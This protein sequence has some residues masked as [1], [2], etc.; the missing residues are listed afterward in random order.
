MAT[1]R[2]EQPA[3]Q[4][5]I[6]TYVD[7]P[8]QA[9]VHSLHNKQNQY[10]QAEAQ[11][12]A[13]ED[14]FLKVQALTQDKTKRDELID[15]Y[16]K[17][18]SIK[19][20]AVRGDYSQLGSYAKGQAQKIKSDLSYGQLGA[21][22]NNYAAAQK[23]QEEQHDRF[24]K[25]NITAEDYQNALDDSHEKY[26]G[27][28]EKVNGSYNSFK[29]YEHADYQ[30]INKQAIDLVNGWQSDGTYTNPQSN[31]TIWSAKEQTFVP[32]KEV[33]DAA[34]NMVSSNEKNK[35]YVK[36]KSYFAS[37]GVNEN[38]FDH[39]TADANLKKIY[40]DKFDTSKF[41]AKQK[42]SLL[43]AHDMYHTAADAAA[44]KESFLKTKLDWKE[45][46]AYGIGLRDKLDKK[47]MV[48]VNQSTLVPGKDFDLTKSADQMNNL[49]LQIKEIQTKLDNKEG[50]AYQLTPQLEDLK[51]QKTIISNTVNRSTSAYYNTK[52]GQNYIN[53]EFNN[54]KTAFPQS[55]IKNI[56]EYKQAIIAA[57]PSSTQPSSRNF[58]LP[59]EM[60]EA[61][62]LSQ[63]GDHVKKESTNHTKA[64]PISY[65]ADI[66][67]STNEKGTVGETNKNLT[68]RVEKNGT[69]YYVEGGAQLD[70]FLKDN[71]E[72][73]GKINVASMDKD[74]DGQYAHYMTIT[75][76]AGHVVTQVPIYPKS[77]LVRQE[78][79]MI[80]ESLMKNNDGSNQH[81]DSLY[82][83]GLQMRANSHFPDVPN[84]KEIALTPNVEGTNFSITPMPITVGNNK[85]ENIAI[86]KLRFDGNTRYKI[87]DLNGELLEPEDP[88][89]P[90]DISKKLFT[91]P[92]EI[93]VALY[94]QFYNKQNAK[95]K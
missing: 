79:D 49:D 11:Q 72:E 7:L 42:N 19:Y 53:K 84:K 12:Q 29:G 15:A 82:Q 13:N 40:G 54:F 43:V 36:D 56:N 80:G 14:N 94:N 48:I 50:E 73:G 39:T 2:Y 76:K 57:K 16:R 22:H 1:N 4:P 87:V 62:Y 52:D 18:A 27:V 60:G 21:I 24:V 51:K 33:Y 45:D 83:K 31:G 86:M 32:Y 9:L 47:E 92:E 55:T 85:N 71:L 70:Q 17:D 81:K 34:Y 95:T 74:I 23:Y 63:A 6:N 46:S 89:D 35:A 26:K 8:Y 66:L 61:A 88:K 59:K 58:G 28:G 75:N 30:D 38:N 69:N 65:S 91:D 78:Q 90:N 20:D 3:N 68:E 25:G 5:V 64:N 41:D 37:K 44:N 67:T 77:G 93:K 10:D